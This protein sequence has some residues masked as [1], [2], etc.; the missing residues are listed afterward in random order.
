MVRGEKR[1]GELGRMDGWGG[2][3]EKLTV[4]FT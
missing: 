2:Q 3:E 1:E 4:S